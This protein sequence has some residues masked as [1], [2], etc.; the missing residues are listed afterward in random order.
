MPIRTPTFTSM[1]S[2]L[3]PISQ[4]P[5]PK[6][7][8][9]LYMTASPLSYLDLTTIATKKL[10]DTSTAL[11]RWTRIAATNLREP[12]LSGKHSIAM[13]GDDLFNCDK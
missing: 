2:L 13:H 5:V 9:T 10:V 7:A 1:V 4:V 11:E 12:R 6:C 8:S 3:M